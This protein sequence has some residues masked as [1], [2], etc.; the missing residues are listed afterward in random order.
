MSDRNRYATA[1][2]HKM[3][4]EPPGPSLPSYTEDKAMREKPLA[5][6]AIVTDEEVVYLDPDFPL[7]E[8]DGLPR[9]QR[10]T[11]TVQDFLDLSVHPT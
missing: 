6:L 7:F 2:M 4:E 11:Y 10:L 8:M 3:G 1:M 5:R 9:G